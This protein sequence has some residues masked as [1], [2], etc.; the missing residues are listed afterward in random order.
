[1]V[2]YLSKVEYGEKG[3]T[4]TDYARLEFQ[5]RKA[6]DRATFGRV[7]GDNPQ[8]EAVKRLMGELITLYAENGIKKQA[9]LEG[10]VTSWGN[11][12]VRVEVK[13]A[14][15]L[16]PAQLDK[17]ASILIRAYLSREVSDK[18]TPLLYRGRDAP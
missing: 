3:L 16:S 5:A 2:E 9:E 18:G 1:M 7:Q 4:D 17:Q 10:K 13:Q 15:S 8:R 14:A 6:I 11:D 12:S